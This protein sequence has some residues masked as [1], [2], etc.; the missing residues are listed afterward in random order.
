MTLDRSL[1]AFNYE[2]STV[3]KDGFCFLS[4]LCE[5][6]AR[7]HH[8]PL[9]LDA[10]KEILDS[11]I[12]KNN[13]TY[14]PCYEGK[15]KEMM[16]ALDR[17]LLEGK[18]ANSIVDICVYAVAKCFSSNICIFKNVDGRALLYF[19]RTDPPSGKDIYMKLDH[20][21]YDAIVWKGEQRYELDAKTREYLNSQGVYFSDQMD[22]NT[23][24]H[25]PGQSMHY[26][27]GQNILPGTLPGI[28][29][30]KKPPKGKTS[31]PIIQD[32]GSDMEA[33][34][35]KG[36]Y[37]DIT[38]SG[39]FESDFEDPALLEPV[40]QHLL[41]EEKY[42]GFE[43]AVLD[44]LG[45]KTA[46]SNDIEEGG[47]S[48]HIPDISSSGHNAQEEVT[49]ER[50]SDSAPISSPLNFSDCNSDSISSVFSDSSAASATRSKQ[51]K[52]KRK[53][54]NPARMVA[55]PVETV[56]LL[57]WDINGDHVYELPATEVNYIDNSKDGHWFVLKNSS[58]AGL[59]GVRKIGPCRGSVYCAYPECQKIG[60]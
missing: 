52:Y 30:K 23:V 4:A 33:E 32:I 40:F 59:N 16:K 39:D 57:P 19:I 14:K 43:D 50:V 5:C 48:T 38:P 53:A 49:Q 3:E 25:Q 29:K 8:L 37:Y 6:L 17:Y 60:E 26:Y 24:P 7:D 35:E 20:E 9:T 34:N 46:Q 42:S 41:F 56:D 22:N 55:C 36:A 10:V 58:R 21:H 27:T 31:K 54:I 47:Q 15:T 28:P 12:Y 45:S 11:E 1:A 2:V 44:N 13:Q 18:W 51:T